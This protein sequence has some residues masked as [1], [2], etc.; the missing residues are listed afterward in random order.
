MTWARKVAGIVGLLVPIAGCRSES[1]EQAGPLTNMSYTPHIVP[2]GEIRAVAMLEAN[3]VSCSLTIAAPGFHSD[4]SMSLRF[5]VDFM[6]Q[7]WCRDAD[8][9]AKPTELGTRIPPVSKGGLS[10]EEAISELREFVQAGI[11]SR[12]PM[13]TGRWILASEAGHLLTQLKQTIKKSY[14]IMGNSSQDAVNRVGQDGRHIVNDILAFE[15]AAIEFDSLGQSI[16]RDVL[17][18]EYYDKVEPGQ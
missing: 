16:R 9:G 7:M 11:D 15:V 4:P 2:A 3:C 13:D 8:P 18:K 6:A 17:R 5:D 14:G 1:V 12:D 10:A